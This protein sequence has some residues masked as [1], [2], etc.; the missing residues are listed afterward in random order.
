MEIES[1]IKNLEAQKEQWRQETA[2][3]EGEQ[4]RLSMQEEAKYHR[5]KANYEDQLARKRYN[6]QLAAQQS[7]QDEINRK[8]EESIRKQEELRR[9]E[10][11][12]YLSNH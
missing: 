7:S 10:L 12:L 2:R 4:R 9:G 8:Q 1:Q 3:I 6:D 11:S 5:E